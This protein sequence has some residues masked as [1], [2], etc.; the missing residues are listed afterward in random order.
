[1]RG[2]EN[3]VHVGEATEHGH[4]LHSPPAQ[5]R[6]VVDEAH[7]LLARSLAQL[8]EQAAAAPSGTDDQRP[9]ARVPLLERRQRAEERALAE[10]RGAD[11]HDGD[12]RVDDVRAERKVAEG[13]VR[14]PDD[15]DGQDLGQDHPG[16]DRGGVSGTG[17]TP[18]ARVQLERDEERVS[19]GQDHRQREQE[20]VLL[21][22]RPTPVHEEQVGGRERGG[23]ECE[24]DRHLGQPSRV[25]QDHAQEHGPARQLFF[26]AF[27]VGQEPGELDEEREA[28]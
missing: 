2:R 18:H 27:E 10:A 14:A 12:Q 23:D 20:D 13:P 11:E 1:M 22:R 4:A 28:D 7:D 5:L 16:H 3:A 15:A 6:V 21:V 19:R 17:E 25:E 9:P 24:V 8:A 26:F